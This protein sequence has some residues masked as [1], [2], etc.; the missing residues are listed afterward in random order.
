MAGCAGLVGGQWQQLPWPLLLP[1][2]LPE[3]L[4]GGRGPVGNG[5]GRQLV[6][7]D[8]DQ[9]QSQEVC[10]GPGLRKLGHK[11]RLPPSHP[12]VTGVDLT[13]TGKVSPIG[14]FGSFYQIGTIFPITKALS[15][16]N[17]L[18]S[19]ACETGIVILG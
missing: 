6:G 7:L 2:Q 15:F 9:L 5:S 13:L 4:G 12:P 17:Y 10:P 3:V 11:P 1:W 18:D 19:W 8:I 16:S 14:C